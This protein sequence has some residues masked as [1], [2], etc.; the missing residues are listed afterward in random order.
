VKILS[1]QGKL[2]GD[3]P[4]LTKEDLDECNA[5]FP[6]YLFVERMADGVHLHTSC[7]HVVDYAVEAQRTLP[8]AVAACAGLPHNAADFCPFCGKPVTVKW[9]SKAGKRKSLRDFR[10]VM[11]LH[12]Q[13]DT[14][15]YAQAYLAR[16]DYQERMDLTADP[17]YFFFAAYRFAPGDSVKCERQYWSGEMYEEENQYFRDPFRTSYLNSYK[18]DSY[19]VIGY[20]AL[21]R[22]CLRYCRY[23][24][25][26]RRTPKDKHWAMIRY[27]SAYCLYPNLEVMMRL[28][29]TDVVDDLVCR[30][31]KNAAAIDWTQRDPRKIF[32]LTKPELQYWMGLARRDIG[33]VALYQRLKRHGQRVALSEL[34]TMGMEQK[35]KLG[36][37]RQCER[38]RLPFCKAVHYLERFTGQRC[39]G[40]WYGLDQVFP[41]W[42]DY[43]EAAQEQGHDMKQEVVL[44]PHDLHGA[45][46]TV[47]EQRRLKEFE[48]SSENFKTLTQKLDKR[49]SFQLSGWHIRPPVSVQEIID[50]GQQLRHCVGGYAQRHANG[51]LAILFLR[52]DSA[53]HTP[54]ATIEMNGNRLVQIHG[55]RNDYGG[56]DPMKHYAAILKP[57]LAWVQAGSK[58]DK[59]GAPI[60][61][62]KKEAKSA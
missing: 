2:C 6:A 58:R 55:Y 4:V 57:W 60:L 30:R 41:L 14:P 34:V 56:P 9:L 11:F 38:F 28:G 13:Q 27:L 39:H 1:Y 16:K 45:H 52:S 10:L 17:E 48:T 51:R 35:H 59:D 20:D 42:K 22:S 24:D 40:G 3:F 15:L 36:L 47:M 19:H 8:G 23:D 54:L 43:L 32:H 7:C 61:P 29:L 62:R 53:P 37:V 33:D 25:W 5:L 46:D 21:E 18:Y 44:Y 50:E 12:A 26:A 31:K 49:Y